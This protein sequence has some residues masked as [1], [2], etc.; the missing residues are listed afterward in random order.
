MAA[1]TTLSSETEDL[2]ESKFMRGMRTKTDFIPAVRRAEK[3][4]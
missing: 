2:A 3:A 4:Y 1:T